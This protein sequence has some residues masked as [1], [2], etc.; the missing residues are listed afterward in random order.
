M[1]R[2]PSSPRLLLHL[3]EG[4]SQPIFAF[5][6]ERQLFFANEATAAWLKTSAEE[7][8]GQ[9]A[10]YET[11]PGGN[12]KRTAIQRIAPPVEAFEGQVLTAE[13]AEAKEH[14]TERR[15]VLYLPLRE[16]DGVLAGVMGIVLATG[17]SLPANDDRAESVALHARLQEIRRDLPPR[18]ERAPLLGDSPAMHKV[19][20][21]VKLAGSVAGRVLILG[22]AGAGRDD[23]AR[24]VHFDSPRGKEGLLIPLAAKLAD[25]ELVQS[26][27]TTFLRSA[28]GKLGTKASAL[29]IQ[30]VDRLSAD[31]QV[32]LVNFLKLPTIDVPV[33]ATAQRSLTALAA[34][35]KFDAALAEALS[36][37]VIRLPKLRQ[38]P[39]DIPLLAQ[40]FLEAW[41]AAAK[42][43]QQHRSGFQSEALDELAGYEWPGE[44]TQLQE[45]VFAAC[46]R[47]KSP[48]IT[49]ADLPDILRLAIGA[50]TYAPKKIAPI[51]LE[52]ELL[53]TEKSLIQQALAQA[54]N[55]K[56]K[57][58]ELLK[59]NRA[60]LLRRMSHFGLM[61]K[62]EEEVMFEPLGEGDGSNSQ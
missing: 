52:A 42:E 7:F 17:Q 62:G 38:R 56:T 55:N 41:N 61:E 29:W 10:V 16:A 53:R 54:K 50:I 22:S 19:R 27:V 11:I 20:E 40:H 15:S 2:R 59:I 33:V 31:A 58:A 44:L 45:I 49:A 4:A 32:E 9:E 8:V 36:P 28:S 34:R 21:Q 1:P 13:I 3:L 23:V 5:D 24:A 47:A 14:A 26:V 48:Q 43:P 18:F 12:A 25:A 35:G 51:D 6:Q 37:L 60:R 39:G 30:D 46:E 57:A